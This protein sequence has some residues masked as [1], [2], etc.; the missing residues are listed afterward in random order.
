MALHIVGSHSINCDTAEDSEALEPSTDNCLSNSLSK[1]HSGCHEVS[2]EENKLTG[3][4]SRS[5][6][7]QKKEVEKAE[8]KEVNGEEAKQ[9][10]ADKLYIHLR[11]NMEKIRE[12]CKD[13]VKRIPVPEQCVIEGKLNHSK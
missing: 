8:S 2:L 9:E 5:V 12:F 1:Q 7:G 10:E 11:D 13:M 3:D 6:R 4:D